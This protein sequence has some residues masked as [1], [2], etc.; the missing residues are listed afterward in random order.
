MRLLRLCALFAILIM[1]ASA[2]AAEL[3]PPQQPVEQVVDHYINALMKADGVSP[4]PLADD[5]TIIRRLSLDLAGRIPTAAESKAFVE[6]TDPEKKVKL[7]DRLMSSPAFVRHQAAMFDAMM[8]IPNSKGG[9]GGLREY[10]VRAL[11]E[12]RPW[13]QI[14]RELVTPDENDPKQKGASDFLKQRV[15]DLDRLTNEVSVTFFGV[16]VSCA[17]CHDHPLVSDWKQDHFFGMKT[18]FARTFDNGGFLAEREFGLLRFKPNK[19][20]EKQATP[21]FLSGKEIELANFR[22]PNNAEQKK[23]KEKF[24]KHKS[25]KTPPPPPEVSARAKLVEV[26]MQE[27]N[28]EFFS[29]SIVN[30][31]WHR[32]LGYGLVNPLDQMHSENPPSH[33]NMLAWLSRDIASHQYDLRRLIRGIA[34]SETYARASRHPSN[35][36]PAPK[37]FAVARLKPLTPMQ[38]A[39]SLKIAA[40]DPSAFDKLSPEDLEKKIEQL[41]SGARGFASNIAMPNDDFQIGIN[42]AL[43]FSNNGRVMQEFLGDGTGA[44]L[45]RVKEMKDTNQAIDL[46]VRNVFCRSPSEDE[47][48]AFV[49][50]LKQRDDRPADA[51]RQLLWAMIASAEFRF[52][53]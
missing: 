5:A 23:E 21:L 18:F 53:H 51:Q 7:V 17:Q 16:N 42:E 12:N 14:F 38:L 37:Y 20:A 36:P 48:K 32:F 47:Q 33:P 52:N 43:L 10:F 30:R 35:E 29:K 45:G 15:A 11:G 19:G 2:T 49:N 39:T 1:P 40:S 28:S 25:A 13:S 50:Y 9:S 8:T 3:L 6:S 46:M 41:E 22:E 26:A 31:M 24:D 44:L 4:A 34:L 27:G